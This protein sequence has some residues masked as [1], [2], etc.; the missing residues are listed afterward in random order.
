MNIELTGNDF[1]TNLVKYLIIVAVVA[2]F[3]NIPLF[4][5]LN[6]PFSYYLIGYDLAYIVTLIF[7][8]RGILTYNTHVNII[9]IIFF[10]H[11][12]S[13]PIMNDSSSMVIVWV[14]LYPIVAFT[15]KRAQKALL[16]SLSFLMVFCLLFVFSLLDESYTLINI[17]T[18]AMMNLVLTIILYFIIK[19]LEAKEKALSAL[20]S[21]LEKKVEEKTEKLQ[22]LNTHLENEILEQVNSI[23]EKDQ[24]IISQSRLAAM[25]EMVGNIAHQ[26]RQPLNALGLIQQKIK[27][28]QDRE[29]L[30]DT[31]LDVNIKKS[32][33]LIDSM[34]T[35]IDDFRDF[36]HPNKEK[37][38]F[39]IAETIQKA[40][41]MVESS[42]EDNN[43]RYTLNNLDDSLML[44]GH[45]NEL[46]Q[47]LLNLLSNARDTLVDKAQ[48]NA[49]VILRV[50]KDGEYITISCSDNGGG[51]SESIISKIFDPYFTTKEKNGTGLGLYMS[52]MIIEDNMD[53]KLEV[54][55]IDEGACFIIKFSSKR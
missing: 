48:K 19:A 29:Q 49:H 47:V 45:Q 31:K 12:L 5:I 24:Y 13:I 27:L 36:F 41:L 4:Y 50:D 51:V 40:F 15:V 26:W 14:A 54:S 22:H 53:G 21:S 11:M 25:G 52:K 16:V 55:N 1:R 44:Y 10:I 43:I 9:L 23:R 33:L 34:S 3:L 20:N 38:M 2:T 28:L 37:S 39:S 30:D 7:M 42:F 46:S 8:I 35:T 17:A 6:R 32:M 18:I